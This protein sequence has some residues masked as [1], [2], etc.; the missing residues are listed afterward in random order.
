M[1]QKIKTI[2]TC[3]N[4]NISFLIR[5]Q[6]IQINSNKIDL[7]INILFFYSFPMIFLMLIKYILSQNMPTS[8][9][10]RFNI[11]KLSFWLKS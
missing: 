8:L 5:F 7:L 4:T 11:A 10:N 2:R 9:P 6:F 1:K 3:W